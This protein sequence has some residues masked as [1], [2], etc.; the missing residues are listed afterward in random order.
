MNPIAEDFQLKLNDL[1]SRKKLQSR[2][3]FAPSCLVMRDN[4]NFSPTARVRDYEIFKIYIFLHGIKISRLHYKVRSVVSDALIQPFLQP[5]SQM[6]F[7]RVHADRNC[8]L[9][10]QDNRQ[11]TSILCQR[12]EGRKSNN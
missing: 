11:E 12:K 5:V 3:Q 10:G 6:V 8:Q 2:L 7:V 4:L 1:A 9:N